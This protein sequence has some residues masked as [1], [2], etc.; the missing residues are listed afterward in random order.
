[1]WRIL[2]IFL[3]IFT[4]K[5]VNDYRI[6]YETKKQTDKNGKQNTKL[7]KQR[8]LEINAKNVV[9]KTCTSFVL[10]QNRCK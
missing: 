6:F 5:I 3:K 2:N 1:M 7:T 9:L 4:L 8:V 10:L